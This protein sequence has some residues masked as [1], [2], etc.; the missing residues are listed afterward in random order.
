[1]LLLIVLMFLST[2]YRLNSTERQW[3]GLNGGLPKGMSTSKY[4]ESVHVT[5]FGKTGLLDEIK[6]RILR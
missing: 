6:L 3:S 2:W 5:L 4:L 1:M